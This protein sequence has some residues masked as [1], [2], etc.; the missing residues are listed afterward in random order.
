MSS[1][2]CKRGARDILPSNARTKKLGRFAL[3]SESIM[4]PETAALD[5]ADRTSTAWLGFIS[6]A[7]AALCAHETDHASPH[8]MI[9]VVELDDGEMVGALDRDLVNVLVPCGS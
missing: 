3:A 9:R 1:A 5:G 4:F 7:L 2:R 6:L 8:R